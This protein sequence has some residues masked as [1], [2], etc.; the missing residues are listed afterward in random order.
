MVSN[1]GGVDLWSGTAVERKAGSL[2][3][4]KD[5]SEVIAW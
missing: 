5:D 1:C 2:S 4:T 3:E